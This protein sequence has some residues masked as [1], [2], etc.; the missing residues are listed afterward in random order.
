[1]YKSRN[2]HTI[3]K[4]VNAIIKSKTNHTETTERSE[5]GKFELKRNV[6]REIK[7]YAK[8]LRK[9]S[10]DADQEKFRE[11]EAKES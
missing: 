3:L 6:D 8:S 11:S 1:M 10:M 2:D 5:K 9:P 7:N 4:H